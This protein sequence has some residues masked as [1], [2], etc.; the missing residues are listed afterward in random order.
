MGLTNEYVGPKILAKIKIYVL[1]RTELLFTLCYE[2][3]CMCKPS[4]SASCFAEHVFWWISFIDL[5]LTSFLQ[6]S[7]IRFPFGFR[8]FL[9]CVLRFLTALGPSNDFS[10]Y[11]QSLWPKKDRNNELDMSCSPHLFTNSQLN[12]EC[13][14]T[15]TPRIGLIYY[16]WKIGALNGQ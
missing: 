6:N 16:A 5:Y 10:Q 13:S 15:P 14:Q 7:H 11:S 12:S 4:F 9:M 1:T 3:P 8:C 2:I